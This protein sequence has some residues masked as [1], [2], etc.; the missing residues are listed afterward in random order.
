MVYT[1]LSGSFSQELR[2]QVWI[3]SVIGTLKVIEGTVLL[4]DLIFVYHAIPI[5]IVE[6]VQCCYY[7]VIYL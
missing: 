7:P 1:R 6:A 5:V 2:A 4:G 3:F